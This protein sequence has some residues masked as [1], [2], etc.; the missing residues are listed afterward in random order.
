M[1]LEDLIERLAGYGSYFF[2]ASIPMVPS[3]QALI[4][5]LA[6]QIIKGNG[7]TEKQR[8]LS[9]RL[10]SKYTSPLS[11]EF[12]R[13]ID[14]FLKSPQFRLPARTLSNNKKILIK[15]TQGELPKIQVYFPYN[16]EIITRI[17]DYK[18]KSPK[19]DST[20]ILWNS[21]EKCWEFG[22]T[23]NNIKF[24]ALL[25]F[26]MDE[27]F[28]RNVEEIKEIEKSIENYVPMV[29]YDGTRYSYKNTVENV[30]QPESNNLVEVLLLARQ[31]GITC[32]D[33]NIGKLL[34]ENSIDPAVISILENTG[35]TPTLLTGNSASL[36]NIIDIIKYSKS[37]LFVIPGGSELD[38]LVY[39]HN[40]LK[41]MGYTDN[42]ISVLFRLD[43]SFGRMCNDYI[44]THLLNSPLEENTKFAFAS[45]KI[46]KPV[47]ELE[48]KFDFIVLYGTNSA[49]YSLKNYIKNHH[50]VISVNLMNSNREFNFG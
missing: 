31:Y 32:W 23:E 7:L 19:V 49:H 13:D 8:S 28:S 14:L 17:K 18:R 30:P 6:D 36:D 10:V 1:Y 39:T 21:S 35:G 15:E 44:K 12:N 38:H 45:G 5:G 20:N 9:I 29:V 27:R 42:Q 50:N 26:S 46:P 16:E 2:S 47:I 37:I 11:T 48:K 25:E 3:D 41:S 33:E 40:F 24:L 34:K 43:S 22:L 4:H